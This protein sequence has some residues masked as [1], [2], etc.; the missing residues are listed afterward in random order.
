MSLCSLKTKLSRHPDDMRFR[1]CTIAVT[2]LYNAVYAPTFPR[3]RPDAAQRGGSFL[4]ASKRRWQ[5]MS[6]SARKRLRV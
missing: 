1:A 5:R 2:T 6:E 3:C 4:R